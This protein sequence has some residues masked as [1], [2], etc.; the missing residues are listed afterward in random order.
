M[1]DAMSRTAPVSEHATDHNA[2]PP[3]YARRTPKRSTIQPDGTC[4]KQ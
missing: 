1:I 2:K 4:M 3:A